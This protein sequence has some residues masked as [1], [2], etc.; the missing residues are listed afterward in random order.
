MNSKRIS[1][2]LSKRYTDCE[3]ELVAKTHIAS[4]FFY[5][6]TKLVLKKVYSPLQ[7]LKLAQVN[8]YMKPFKDYPAS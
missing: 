1:D 3:G 8:E 7:V 5:S 6:L 2:K 4:G